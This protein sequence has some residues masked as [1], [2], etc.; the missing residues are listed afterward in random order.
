[1]IYLIYFFRM[2]LMIVA[3][4]ALMR[5]GRDEQ[6]VA[7]L[8]LAG[9]LTTHFLISPM[10][11]RYDGVEWSIV[12][13]DVAMFLGFV[14]VALR[15][16]RFWPLWIAGLQLTT[17]LG[18]AIKGVQ[19]ELL[20]YAYAVALGFWAYPII[21]ILAIGTWRHSRRS[22]QQTLATT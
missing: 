19:S 6:R 9:A 15:S 18:H 8:C 16:D 12:I 13:V 11:E 7:L 3:A 20:P 2:S 4:Y 1:M 17:L 10:V 14:A 21:F 5:G 22:R